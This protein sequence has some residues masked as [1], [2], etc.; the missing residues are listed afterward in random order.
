MH[1]DH[2]ENEDFEM[3]SGVALMDEYS[4]SGIDFMVSVGQQTVRESTV[5]DM[6]DSEPVIVREGSGDTSFIKQALSL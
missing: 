2:E 1:I 6:T 3:P 5:I 4:T